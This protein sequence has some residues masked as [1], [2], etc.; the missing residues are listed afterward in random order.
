MSL[1]RAKQY[2]LKAAREARLR[3][4]WR[5]PD[6]TFEQAL[7]R[8]LEQVYT[9]REL[10]AEIAQLADQL[11]PHGERSSLAQLLVKLTAPGVPDFYQGSELRDECLVDPDNRRPVDLAHREARLRA[12][13]NA[14]VRELPR[15]LDAMKLWTIGRVLGVRRKDP[16]RFAGA[17][18]ALHAIG[19]QAHRV[20][21]F[22][23]GDVLVTIVPRLGVHADGF[24]DTT[25]E[26][27]PGMWRDVLSDQTF[28]G[29]ACALGQLW[30]ALPI[31]LLTRP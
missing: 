21:A 14:T 27:P 24:G 19:P 18:H 2:A 12:L 13:A 20:F 25:L 9:D 8:W 23:R 4:S 22:A 31:A 16:A 29:G 26:I 30:R 7:D 5:R 6:E 3:T 10:V 17:Y 28:S 11:R 1:A 15:D